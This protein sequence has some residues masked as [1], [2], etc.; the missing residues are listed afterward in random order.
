MNDVLVPISP[1]ELLDKITILRIKE[2]RMT[3]AGRLANVRHE[4][5]SLEAAVRYDSQSAVGSNPSERSPAPYGSSAGSTMSG[6]SRVIT[7]RNV[8]RRCV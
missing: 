3:D 2:A 1:G 4:L 8:A 5:A 6:C 7:S